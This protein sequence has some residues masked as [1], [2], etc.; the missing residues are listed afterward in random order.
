M[1]GWPCR[2]SPHILFYA[3]LS[4][5]PQVSS[6]HVQTLWV[7][8]SMAKGNLQMWLSGSENVGVILDV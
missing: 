2:G 6:P 1:E 7:L 5:G 3:R 8:P 4:N